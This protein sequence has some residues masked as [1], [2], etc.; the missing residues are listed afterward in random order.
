MTLPYRPW[1]PTSAADLSRLC[2]ALT[3]IVDAW[4]A[5]WIVQPEPLA[6]CSDTASGTLAVRRWH[7]DAGVEL[8]VVERSFNRLLRKALDLPTGMS[9][10]PVGHAADIVEAFSD[11]ML[12]DLVTRIGQGLSTNGWNEGGREADDHEQARLSVTIALADDEALLHLF[13]TPEWIRD[14][15]PPA[16]VHPKTPTTSRRSALAESR[17]RL[18]AIAGSCDISAAELA[19][20]AVGDVLVT[21]TS[22]DQPMSLALSSSIDGTHTPVAQATPIRRESRMVMAVTSVEPIH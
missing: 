21:G 17:V 18:T 12:A 14:N 22:L 9:L 16:T 10:P 6:S 8:R 19:G 4:H 20:L 7:D 1:W 13:V 11:A 3:T 2:A 15:L 5:R